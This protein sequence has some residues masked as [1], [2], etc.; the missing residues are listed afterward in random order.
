VAF[1][2]G[3]LIP[4]LSLG[5]L[6]GRRQALRQQRAA[7]RGSSWGLACVLMALAM[8][9]LSRRTGVN[10]L[11]GL[12][13]LPL[14]W[15]AALYLGGWGVL[16]V[17][18]FPIGFLVFGL[19]LYRG[20]LSSVGFLLQDLTARGS[21]FA[22]QVVGLP[23][24]RDGVILSSDRFTF[25]VAEACSGMSSLL[26]LLAL[27]TL[28]MSFTSGRLGGRAAV[29]LSVL[30]LVIVANTLRVTA[31]LV[32]AWFFGPDAALGFFHGAS[33]L[34]L[35]GAALGG[36]LLVSRAAGCRLTVWGAA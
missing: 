33:S 12:A 6:W 29:L 8:F 20:L 26:S 36:L 31:V 17:I 15:G 21:A 28:W 7:A 1:T 16:R 5:L 13:V 11:G 2:F 10:V 22:G 23:V 34:V 24:V 19:G 3:F 30:P 4:V 18:A 25:V 9:V 35:F 27:A 14:L 32:V